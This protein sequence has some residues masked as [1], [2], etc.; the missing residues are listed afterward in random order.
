M[1][2]AGVLDVEADANDDDEYEVM[3]TATDSHGESGDA[4]TVTI[5]VTDVNEAP[6]F[7]AV[8]DDATAPVNIQGMAAD[9]QEK[10]GPVTDNELAISTYTATDPEG[11]NVTLSLMGDDA[12]LFELAADTE[13]GNAVNRALSFRERPDFENPGD[14]NGD[15]VYEVS[16]RASDGRLNTDRMV[17]IKVTDADEAGEVEVP[18][19]ALIG[20]E[21]TATLTD[22]DTGAP[23]PAQFI[24][25]V[26]TWYRLATSGENL[27]DDPDEQDYNAI[28]GATS[29]AYTP[30]VADRGMFLRAMVTYTDRT[31]DEDNVD[32]NNDATNNFVGFMNTATSNATTAVRNNPSNQRPVF[33]EGSRTVRLV[34]E[35]TEALTGDDDDAADD[36]PA[37]NVGGGPVVATDADGDTPTYTLTGSDMFRVRTDGQIEVSDKADLDYEK[38]SSH[39]VMLTAT[40]PS[41]AANNS[42]SIE[43]TIYVTD[44]DERPMIT[45]G[46]LTLTGP[47]GSQEYPENGTEAVGI[48]KMDGAE[49][50]GATMELMGDDAGDFTLEG[51]GMSR[52]LK[53]TSTPN[54]E[55]P[56]DMDEDNEYK[57]TVMIRKGQISDMA[58]LTVTVTDEDE[59]GRLAGDASPTYAEDRTDA[60]GTYEVR[61]GDGSAVDWSLEG[62]DASQFTLDGTGMSRMLM[63]GSAPDF[64]APADADGDNGYMVT[65]KAEAGGEEEMVEI[66]INV[67][68][69][70][71]HGTLAGDTNVTYAEDRTDAV[72]TYEVTGG[73]GTSTVTWSLEGADVSQFTLDGTGMSR[74]L[75]F[76]SA[77]DFEAPADADGDNGY[78]VTVK[79]EAGGEEEM[80][81]ITINV[82][83][84]D[85]LGTLTGDTNVTYAEDRTDAVGDYE[86]TGGDGTSTVTWSLEGAVAGQ[87]TLEGTGMSRTLMFSSAPDFEAPAD[88]DGDNEYMVTVKAEAGGEEEM[89]G[90]TINVTDVAELGTLAGDASVTYAEGRMDAVATYEVTGGDGSAIDWSLEGAVAGQFT[91]EGTGMSR[92]LMFNSAPDFEAP[93]DADGDN[94]YMVTVKAE[95]GGEEEMV[96]VTINVTDVDELGTLEGD[97][98]VT[99]AEDR[100]DAV[101]TYEVRGGDG[102]A[103]TWSLEGADAGQFTLDGTGMSLML[104]FGSAPDFEAPADADGDNGYMVTVKAEAGGEEEML[105]IT[106]NVTDV[107]EHGTLEGDTSVT[108]AE[109]RTDAVGTYEVTGG[110]GSAITWSLEGADAGQFTLDGTGMSR[111]L[112]FGSAPDFEAQRQTLTA[113]TVTWSPSRP[114]P[115]AK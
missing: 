35:N 33:T 59:L 81:E 38:K 7:G 105:G 83:D 75:M 30:V 39:T 49:A 84:A 1:V 5:T 100:T 98:S 96:E 2:A 17:T 94:G 70:D 43:V 86:V 87:F 101:G 102:S 66:T 62:A 79:A 88:A 69:V 52:T 21:L 85:E 23:D 92:T 64:E 9:H 20:V 47:K 22:S 28:P 4:V 15:N 57:V 93:A 63:F 14:R 37:D 54:F 60:V 41:G 3:V 25:Q 42:A 114:R 111:M 112:M 45:E 115:A 109:D 74:T 34:E 46:V 110:D 48:Y 6:T 8:D 65:V 80:V 55:M 77:P 113:T 40:D 71:E 61:G 95:A 108:Y 104:M 68:D 44:L 99:Y 50:A 18:Q 78:M 31:R 82:T 89:V 19:D 32:N 76:S 24:D 97:A 51:S 67:T 12:A 106:I 16:V 107:A 72:G 91:L 73:D 103:I 58:D 90:I 13:T 29:D 11:A 56:M 27:E 26:W 53:F 36:N 10:T